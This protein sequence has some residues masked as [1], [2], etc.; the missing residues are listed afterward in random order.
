[1]EAKAAEGAAKTERP[2]A[3]RPR[4]RSGSSSR[5]LKR[6]ADAVDLGGGT[7]SGG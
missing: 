7:K 6:A 5:R 2:E 1:M 4:G 3:E